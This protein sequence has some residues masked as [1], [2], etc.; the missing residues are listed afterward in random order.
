MTKESSDSIQVSWREWL[1]L[2]LLLANL[3]VWVALAQQKPG[4][5]LQVSFL[6]VGQGDA[7]FI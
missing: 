4:E 5:N 1:V 2:T 3:F 7:I 6:D